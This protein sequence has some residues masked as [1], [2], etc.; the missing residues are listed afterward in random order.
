MFVVIIK[1]LHIIH[2]KEMIIGYKDYHNFNLEQ[3]IKHRQVLR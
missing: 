2:I 1:D 3:H